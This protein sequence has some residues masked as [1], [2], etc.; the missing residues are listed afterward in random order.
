MTYHWDFGDG[1]NSAMQNPTH[2]Y[3][4]S[5][6]YTVSL[7]VTNQFGSVNQNGCGFHLGRLPPR[8]E[9]FRFTLRRNYPAHGRIYG[10]FKEHA[11]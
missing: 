4:S 10:S 11:R 7:T 9:L 8:S 1:T 2:T 3:L 5:G 6:E